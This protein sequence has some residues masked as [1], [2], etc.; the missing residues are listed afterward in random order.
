[1]FACAAQ[2]HCTKYGTKT[3]HFAQIAS[4][5]RTQGAQNPRAAIQVKGKHKCVCVVDDTLPHFPHVHL[6]C[7]FV[8]DDTLPYHR[9]QFVLCNI[10][11]CTSYFVSA[12]QKAAS[13]AD[14]LSKRTI[15][16]PITIAMSA[17]TGDGGA[18]A[19]LCS[20]RFMEQNNL[21]VRLSLCHMLAHVEHVLTKWP[22]LKPPPQ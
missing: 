20:Q 13:A 2:E 9:G 21:Q 1:M 6:K 8:I 15:C 17:P 19:V 16:P 4:K 18:A 14:I 7:V 10:L 22:Y 11:T 12:I 5:N 3:E